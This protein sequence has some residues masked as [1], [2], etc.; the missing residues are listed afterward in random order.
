MAEG[1][2]WRLPLIKSVSEVVLG[3]Q[4]NHITLVWYLLMVYVQLLSVC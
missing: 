1:V 2:V 4:A 3:F